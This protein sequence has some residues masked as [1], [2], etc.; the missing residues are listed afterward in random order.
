MDKLLYYA[1]VNR[2]LVQDSF[3]EGNKGAAM[4]KLAGFMNNNTSG[5]VDADNSDAI[6]FHM[7]FLEWLKQSMSE[8]V[9]IT[10]QREGAIDNRETVG[11]VERSVLQSSHITE[12]LYLQHE[13]IKKRVYECFL[14]TAKAAMKGKSMKFQH[15]LSDGTAKII[16]IDG[17]E[18]SENDYGLVVDNGKHTQE[19]IQKLEG[20]AQAMVQNQMMSASTLVKIFSNAPL[21]DITRTIQQEETQMK[22]SQQEQAEKDREVQMQQIQAQMAMEQEKI[23][24]TERNNMRDNETKLIIAGLNGEENE[25]LNG[26]ETPFDPQ[27]KAELEERMKEHSDKMALE[28]KRLDQDKELRLKDISVK[29]KG[30]NKRKVSN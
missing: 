26:E 16:D 13:N 21:S 11:G 30:I 8:M 23:A 25:G 29:E 22:Q 6:Q 17:D 12:W 27:K 15:I 7:N 19:L 28:Y 18:F 9:G 4:G 14:E 10:K 1:K 3:K 20:L 5:L 2:I 24:I